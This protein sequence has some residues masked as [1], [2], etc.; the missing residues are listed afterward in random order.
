MV[1]TQ[2]FILPGVIN[3]GSLTIGADDT[4]AVWLNGH[5]LKAANWVQDG[6]CAHG[7]IGCE[8]SEI[9]TLSLTGYLQQGVNILQIKE[10]QRDGDVSGATWKAKMVSESPVPEPS[11]YAM[12]G[13]G[14]LSLVF[15]SYRRKS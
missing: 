1:F 11:T 7:P 8:A 6:A 2:Q 9:L 4:A 12:M 13:A 3:T 10:Y 15:L 5:L 14:L